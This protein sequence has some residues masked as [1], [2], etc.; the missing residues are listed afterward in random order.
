MQLGNG[1]WE[2][3]AYNE[4]QQVTMMGLGP[5]DSSQ[6]LLR[7]DLEYGR[8]NLG[9]GQVDANTNN[10]SLAKQKIT[11]PAAGQQ[12][13]FVAQQYYSYDSLNRIEIATENIENPGQSPEFSW[14]QWFTYD[15]YGNRRFDTTDNRTTTIP[16]GCWAAVCNP[17]ISTSNNQ[18]SASQGYDYDENGALTLDAAGQRFGYDAESHQKEFFSASNQTTE[19]DATYHYDG[20]GRRVK[21]IVGTEVTI[22]VY[23][24]SGLLAEEYS[25]TVVPVEQAK[26]SYLTTDHLGSPRVIT[27]QNGA[28]ISRKDFTAFGEE[29][30]SSQRV[31]GTN[32]NG[33]DPPNVRQDYTGYEK[34]DESGLEFAQARY[35][36]AGHGRFTS[37]DPL[38]ASA[39]IRNPQTFNRYSYVINNP[40]KFVDPLGLAHCNT[41]RCVRVGGGDWFTG[42]YEGATPEFSLPRTNHP[43]QPPAPTN[44][45]NITVDLNI[46]YDK[47][48]YTL[49]EV[50]EGLKPQISDLADT[51]GQIGIEFNVTYTP[52]T[53][54][55]ARTEITSG[56]VEG[57]LNVFYFDDSKNLYSYSK[58]DTGSRQIFI[59]QKKGGDKVRAGTLSHEVGHAFGLVGS[60]T[61]TAVHYFGPRGNNIVTNGID[62]LTSDAQIELANTWLRNGLVAYS[63]NWVD[64]YRTATVRVFDASYQRHGIG[65]YRDVPRTPSVWDL[66]RDGAR[67]IAAQKRK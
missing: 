14:R 33:Y 40:Y 44:A 41:G 3:A 19:P 34:D 66:Y 36:N 6:S 5:T 29:V 22:F 50:Q 39:T 62:N 18:L 51:F 30:T 8:L 12:P 42:T 56:A 26:V 58:Y 49:S 2:T 63:R 35:Y 37:V 43:A 1:L 27:D 21:K 65:R 45:E 23:D 54:N 52:G 31:G 38:T 4:R 25:T 7:L 59:S 20:E 46:V 32:G 55:S 13:A 17:D 15:R 10:G 53:V 24:A 64:N 60:L 11:V 16:S 67:Q 47:S 61:S 57:S 48:Q 28:V 9:T